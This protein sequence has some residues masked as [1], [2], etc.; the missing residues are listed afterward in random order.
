MPYFL[1]ANTIVALAFGTTLS[2]AAEHG[3]GEIDIRVPAKGDIE[4]LS[5]PHLVVGLYRHGATGSFKATGVRHA[6]ALYF[7][8]GRILF[9]SSTDPRDG[10]GTILIERG[11]V[12]SEQLSAANARIRPG[13]PLAEVL[14]K[15]GVSMNAIEDAGRAKV[16][17]ILSDMLSWTSGVFEF[18]DG[19]LPRE[20]V[21]LR[22]ST[23]RVLLEAVRQM[24]DCGFA[25]RH[26]DMETVF[27]PAPE[28][29]KALSEVRAEVW[30]VLRH[31]DGRRTLMEAIRL[32]GLEE[33]EATK[34]ACAMLFLGIV[35]KRDAGSSA[36]HP[37]RLMPQR[38]SYHHAA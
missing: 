8:G 21:D 7:R 29:A 2:C 9:A 6:K 11:R 12:T 4:P 16:E 22:L 24:R 32:A 33:V 36:A 5:F 35:R 30:P 34:T 27:E 20:S 14:Q 10:L 3:G 1:C 26:V 17:R 18:E 19:V 13:H 38:R 23:E 37:P 15:G 25:L 28:G 31:L